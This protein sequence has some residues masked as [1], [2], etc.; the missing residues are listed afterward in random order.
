[1]FAMLLLGRLPE[2]VPAQNARR[3][4][5]V[6]AQFSDDDKETL[7]EIGAIMGLWIVAAQKGCAVVRRAGETGELSIS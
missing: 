5:L 1:M 7:N 4:A 2:V 6:L 3:A